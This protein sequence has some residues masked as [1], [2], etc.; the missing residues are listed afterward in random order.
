MYGIKYNEYI[1]GDT[2][3]VN[4]HCVQSADCCQ[5]QVS[6]ENGFVLRLVINYGK[7]SIS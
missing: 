4:I 3:I 2:D 1:P 5:G 6:L 7:D